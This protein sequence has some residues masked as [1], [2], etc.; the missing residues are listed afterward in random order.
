M[1]ETPSRTSSAPAHTS[2]N[3][4]PN[5][6][7]GAHPATPKLAGI[8]CGSCIL[9][10]WTVCLIY[11]WWNRRKEKQDLAELEANRKLK[12]MKADGSNPNVTNANLR[13]GRSGR[14]SGRARRHASG[15]KLL[16]EPR[17]ESARASRVE[18]SVRR[19]SRS[20]AGEEFRM[21][22]RRSTEGKRSGYNSPPHGLSGPLTPMKEV[23][24]DELAEKLTSD[25]TVPR[26]W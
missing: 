6:H 25:A 19:S 8:V 3:A 15:S 17:R 11:W 18:D 23:P 1:S 9:F 26:K 16:G 4:I 13:R 7:G 20:P 12:E 21:H 10:A 22:E 2:S 24:M 5:L 14:G